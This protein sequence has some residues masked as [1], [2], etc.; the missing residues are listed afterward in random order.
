VV[1]LHRPRP[2]YSAQSRDG[3]F[4]VK[5][6][7]QRKRRLRKLKELRQEAWRRMHTSVAEQHK[8]LSAVL[9]GHF[10]YFG[11]PGN[12]RS[13]SAFLFEVRKHW[14]RVLQLISAISY[15]PSVLWR[16]T[17]ALGSNAALRL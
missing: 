2:H 6:K 14:R 11:L 16:T 17:A 15:S 9:R 5:R 13:L 12:S 10:A 7:T 4:V 1:Q 3:Q 8:W